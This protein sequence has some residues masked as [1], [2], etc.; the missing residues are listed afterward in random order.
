MN[1]KIPYGLVLFAVIA[2]I[3]SCL[4]RIT[5][6]GKVKGSVKIPNPPPPVKSVFI[7]VDKSNYSFRETRRSFKNPNRLQPAGTIHIVI[8]KSDY[9]L[10]VFDETGWFATYP[11][12]FG[13]K[14]L[15]DKMMQGDRKTPEG[16]FIILSKRKHEKWNKFILLDY[17][18]KK[19]WEKFNQRKAKGLIPGKATIGGAIGIHGTLPHFGD[20]VN[21][22][23]NWTAGCVS[24]KN[25]DLDELYVI[26]RVG[27]KVMIRK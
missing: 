18:N 25:E 8:D 21:G 20:V 4:T 15:D 19:S 26:I 13:S 5:S 2:L 27:T 9:S 10:Q 23:A 14:S 24:L 6:N 16:T 3:F 12:V 1:Y 22:Y 11:V 17:P 7:I